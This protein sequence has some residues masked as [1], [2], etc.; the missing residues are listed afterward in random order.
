M[1]EKIKRWTINFGKHKGE[2]FEDLPISYVK[3]LVDSEIYLQPAKKEHYNQINKN[4]HNYLQN[5][6]NDNNNDT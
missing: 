3:W 5:R 2:F 4:I 1:S 6:I